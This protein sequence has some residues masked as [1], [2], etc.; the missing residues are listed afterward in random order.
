M[1]RRG[2]PR[3]SGAGRNGSGP[4]I[5]AITGASGEPAHPEYTERNRLAQRRRDD[6]RQV[7][8]LAKMERVT[9]DF[10]RGIRDIPAGSVDGW[11]SCKEGTR[12]RS[13]LTVIFNAVC[14][15]R[16]TPA[17]IFAKRGRRWRPAARPASGGAMTRDRI[18]LDL[19]RLELALRRQPVGGTAGGGAV[20]GSRSSGAA[21]QIVPCIVVAAPGSQDG[22]AGGGA[23]ALVLIDGLSP[24]RRAASNSRPGRH[25][26]RRA[27]DPAT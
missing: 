4:L 10:S 19:H 9:A 16:V 17:T 20:G 27:M 21:R 11:R 25:G 2:L 18:E 5:T 3:Q 7:S 22:D 13:N 1:T 26:W 14:D 6:E 24:G 12:G 8:R 23:Q 15:Q